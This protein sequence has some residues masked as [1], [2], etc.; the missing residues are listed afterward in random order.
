MLSVLQ[1]HGIA[2]LFHFILLLR[3]RHPNIKRKIVTI[4][5]VSLE[6]PLN[7]KAK[8]IAIFVDH[9]VENSVI[10]VREGFHD[11][12]FPHAYMPKLG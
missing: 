1:Q 11:Q 6:S 4:T 5:L 7:M 9:V 2:D 10:K 12:M 3:S 8:S